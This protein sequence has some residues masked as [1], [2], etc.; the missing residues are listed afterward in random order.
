[1][2]DDMRWYARFARQRKGAYPSWCL[3]AHAL[4]KLT[5]TGSI[6]AAATARLDAPLHFHAHFNEIGKVAANLVHDAIAVTG[7]R[8]GKASDQVTT[9][10]RMLTKHQRAMIRAVAQQQEQAQVYA[11]ST[12]QGAAPP[13]GNGDEASLPRGSQPRRPEAGL[14]EVVPF[15][16]VAAAVETSK[17]NL[18][19]LVKTTAHARRVVAA[20]KL[21]GAKLSARATAASASASGASHGDGQ[22][23]EN[24]LANADGEYEREL[25]A[26]LQQA[27][28]ERSSFGLE[29]SS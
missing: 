26:I 23:L 15:P 3:P 27:A 16:A 13:A 19:H 8:L 17:A 20:F 22:W 21:W 28:A 24:Q 6:R 5:P 4:P 2:L 9:F 10:R 14:E 7:E 29:P 11:Y 12:A 1:V 18:M 25:Q